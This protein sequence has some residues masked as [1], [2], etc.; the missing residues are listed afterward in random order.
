VRKERRTRLR[1]VNRAAFQIAADRNTHHHRT[2]R[3]SVRTPT[4]QCYLVTDLMKRGKM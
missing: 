1:V 3:I 2:F 4:R